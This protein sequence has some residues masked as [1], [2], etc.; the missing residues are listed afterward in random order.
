MRIIGVVRT[1]SS[2]AKIY[3]DNEI[4]L[5]RV[6]RAYAVEDKQA[7]RSINHKRCTIIY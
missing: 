4:R 3:P 2:H 6:H 1:S 7:M 5:L